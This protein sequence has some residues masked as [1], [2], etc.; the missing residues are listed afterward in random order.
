MNA[1][2]RSIY[3]TLSIIIITTVTIIMSIHSAYNYT[4]TKNKLIEDMK[5]NSRTTIISLKNNLKNLVASYAVNEYDNLILNEMKRRDIFAIIVDDYNMGKI[6]GQKGYVNGKIKNEQLS[7][8]NYDPLNNSQKKQL[9]NCY[10]S[11]SFL[12]KSTND[13]VSP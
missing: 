10:Y 11:D 1:H 4:Q 5:D 12:I 8:V 7:I 3:L 6:L 2:R 9:D 13:S